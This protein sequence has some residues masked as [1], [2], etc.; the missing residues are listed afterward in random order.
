[1]Y[2]QTCLVKWNKPTIWLS[3]P[4]DW[5]RVSAGSYVLVTSTITNPELGLMTQPACVNLARI[6]SYASVQLHWGQ[7]D[8][9]FRLK[10]RVD[11]RKYMSWEMCCTP[12]G[13]IIPTVSLRRSNYFS[14][15]RRFSIFSSL[16]WGRFLLFISRVGL[17]LV[18]IQ[19]GSLSDPSAAVSK[20]RRS[21]GNLF[22]QVST[23]P[24]LSS[25]L[26]KILFYLI[27]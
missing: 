7:T 23:L 5:G 20:C 11:A 18:L 16:Y 21:G 3:P 19:T 2:G 24:F 4:L 13:P 10:H 15:F 1:M 9:L 6:D 27:S 26:T 22:C 8:F 25:F 12:N 17:V 14:F